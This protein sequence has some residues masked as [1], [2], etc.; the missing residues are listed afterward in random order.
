MAGLNYDVKS[1]V[2]MGILP[3]KN[4]CDFTIKETQLKIYKT[5]TK[6]PLNSPML[7]TCW[8]LRGEVMAPQE[9][10]IKCV[11]KEH[12]PSLKSSKDLPVLP[13]VVY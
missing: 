1:I 6:V 9:P 13:L 7:V 8:V 3:L 10:K 12:G 2:G 11:S 5:V 4:E